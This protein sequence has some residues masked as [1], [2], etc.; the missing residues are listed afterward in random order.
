MPIITED[1][2]MEFYLNLVKEN[3]IQFL[4]KQKELKTIVIKNIRILQKESDMHVKI[5]TAKNLW[6]ALF[7]AAMTFIDPD[8][9]G[10]DKLFLYFNRFVEFEELIFASEAFYRD[11]TLHCLWVYF[12]GEYIFHNPQFSNLFVNKERT[13]KNTSK[14]RKVL[15]SLEHPNIF[16]NFIKRLDN[17]IGITKLSDSIRCVIALAHDLGYP[18]K[19]IDKINTEI[20]KLLPYFAISEFSKFAFEYEN[21][22]QF[23]LENFLQLLSDEIGMAVD[24]SGLEFEELQLIATPYNKIGHISTLIEN[25]IEPD[26]Q[27]IQELKDTLEGTSEKEKYLLRKIFFGKGKI[28]K[29]MSQVLRYANDFEDYRHGIMSSYLLMK[30]LNSFSNIKITYSNPDDLP[31]EELDFATIYGK[32]KILKAMADHTSSGYQIMDFDN[33]SAQLILIDEIEE[34]SRI[35]RA[36]QYRTFVN[37][38]C[39]CEVNMENECLCIDFIFDD[40]EIDDLDPSRAFKD[41]CRRFISVLD[42]PNLTSNISIRFRCIGQLKKDKKTYE[43]QLS[44]NHVKISIDGVEKEDINEYLKSAEFVREKNIR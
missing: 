32:M 42:I 7:E 21:I 43:L 18:L 4:I 13:I 12:L 11:H 35:S 44:K 23:F 8:K 30:T 38:F 1:T 36:N 39:K 24:S 20:G 14:F 28:D 34:F 29:S 19:K 25:E 33:Y 26:P 27:L 6:K 17:I 16:G 2:V 5:K 37:Q 3:S 10:F 31:L 22:Q 9:Q 15:V 41:K 40:N